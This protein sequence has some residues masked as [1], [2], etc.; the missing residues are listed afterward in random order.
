MTTHS[1]KLVKFLR[2]LVIVKFFNYCQY[3]TFTVTSQELER[4]NCLCRLYLR[5]KDTLALPLP[6]KE[7]EMFLERGLVRLSKLGNR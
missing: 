3:I 7:T 4:I 2:C 6:G 5:S 1:T